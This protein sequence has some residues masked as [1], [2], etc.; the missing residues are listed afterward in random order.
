MP[1]DSIT[2]IRRRY[3][4]AKSAR[5]QWDSLLG[6]AYTYAYPEGDSY[7]QGVAT[8][9]ANRRREVYDATAPIAVEDA[10]NAHAAVLTPSTEKFFRLAPLPA[11]AADVAERVDVQQLQEQFDRSR[12]IFFGHLN[13]SNFHSVVQA[14]FCQ[15]MISTGVL[16]F[17]PTPPGAATRFSFETVPFS[18]IYLEP[19]PGQEPL[20]VWHCGTY[21][22][23]TLQ[24]RWPAASLSSEQ[25]AMAAERPEAMTTV[26]TGAIRDLETGR[27]RYVVFAETGQADDQLML[28][29]MQDT[30]PFIVF[31]QSVAPGETYGRGAVL[32]VLSDIKTANKVV[33]LTLKNATIAISGIWQADD[34]GVI[35]PATIRLVPGAII[36]K[37]VG[38]AGLTPLQAPG[39]FDVSGLIL[40]QLQARIRRAIVGPEMPSME[41]RRDVTAY[42]MAVRA[43]DQQKMQVMPMMRMWA[44]L[45]V[46]L[47]RRG[48]DILE[49]A[50]EV[51]MPPGL[52]TFTE[53]VPLSRLAYTQGQADAMRVQA[54]VVA[55]AQTTGPQAAMTALRLHETNEY[56]LRAFGVPE[57]L[58]LSTAEAAELQAELAAQQQQQ[59]AV[60]DLGA[61][62]PAIAALGTLAQQEQAP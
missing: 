10:A 39:R 15:A 62:A 22:A 1:A 45:V 40:E 18:A 44:E 59:Q 33:E 9:G 17:N 43:E 52:G 56:I 25:R 36:P 2:E 21:R 16:V 14:A 38:S 54:G 47:V 55:A 49:K 5:S 48:F 7:F 30:S 50:G 34:D 13:G 42:E 6:D 23:D 60:A 28:D 41:K 29:E 8:S 19:G 58:I 12:D 32:K 20:A 57:Q 3:A 4:T 51:A 24:S 61:V 53:V 11:I 27:W 26:I 35:N 31:R 37:A 46:P